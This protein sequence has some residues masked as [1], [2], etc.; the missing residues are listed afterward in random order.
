MS[1]EHATFSKQDVLCGLEDAIPEAKS[2]N[3]EASPEDAITPATTA[4]IKGVEPQ[5]VTNQG[6]DSTVLAEYAT[7]SAKT[8]PPAVAEA[9]PKNEVTVPVTEIDNGTPKDLINPWAASPVMAENWIIPTTRQGDKPVSPTPP[10]QVGGE[11][12]CMLT[13]TASMGRLNLKATGVTPGDTVIASVGRMNFGNPCMV[14]SFL[15]LS[16]EEREGSHQSTTMDEL[17]KRDSAEDQP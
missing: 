3:T 8:N 11:G 10:D 16:Q 9:L 2:Q 1:R 17:A 5:S 7:S 13:V 6:T 4:N 12:P 14:A 15:G